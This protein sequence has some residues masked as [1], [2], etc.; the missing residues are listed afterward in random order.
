MR[1]RHCRTGPSNWP[2]RTSSPAPCWSLA[3]AR[4]CSRMPGASPTGRP[5]AE[6]A[7]HEVPHRFDEQ[8]V[9]RRGDPAARRS[10]RARPRRPDRQKPTRLPEPGGGLEGHGAPSADPHRRHRRHLRPKSSTATGSTSATTPT[11]S[12]C[13][14]N[15]GAAFEPGSRFEY[16]NYGF[17]LLGALVE[18][19][20]GQT[21][22]D[23]VRSNIF[24]PAGM[25]STDSLPETNDVPN[26]SV[27]YMRDRRR[28]DAQHRHPAMARHR[29]RRRLLH[30]R[31]SR[32]LRPGVE[33]GHADLQ[34]D[35]RRSD[36]TPR[37]YGSAS[38]SGSSPH[39]STAT[40]AGRPG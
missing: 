5:D 35:A 23:Y 27:G 12:T 18:A 26:R 2:T 28:L 19:V 7:G 9:H 3:T 15:E 22:Y 39:R 6:H 14:A 36:R 10:R 34:A 33:L 4:C 20:T 24:Q 37:G 1:W 31:R 25:T 40:V 21:Y 11:T 8:D 30:R 17:V 32:P 38:A 16:S 13:T 29:R